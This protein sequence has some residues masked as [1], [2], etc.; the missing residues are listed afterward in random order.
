MA[1]DRSIFH[2]KIHAFVIG[3]VSTCSTTF[4]QQ[5]VG[6][7]VQRTVTEY[8]FTCPFSSLFLHAWPR[9]VIGWNCKYLQ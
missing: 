6:S 3:L 2:N 8:F 7:Q 5:R 9:F 1:G 4:Y